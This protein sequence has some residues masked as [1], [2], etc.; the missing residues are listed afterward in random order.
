M[1]SG[2][3]RQLGGIDRLPSG[4]WRARLIDPATGRRTSL[5]TFKTK[6]GR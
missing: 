3:R 5:G 2:R 6:C 4:R 1:A